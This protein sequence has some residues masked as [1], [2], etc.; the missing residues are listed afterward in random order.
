MDWK[1]PIYQL[2]EDNVGVNSDEVCYLDD[3]SQDNI[4]ENY[5]YSILDDIL[6][7]DKV[8]EKSI[9][10]QHYTITAPSWQDNKCVGDVNCK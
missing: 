1:A 8:E 4:A 5:G 10:E 2:N 3:V 7:G 9:F 6:I